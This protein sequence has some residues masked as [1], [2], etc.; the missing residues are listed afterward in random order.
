LPASSV[1]RGLGKDPR[2][3][4]ER[5]ASLNIS[6]VLQK[7]ASFLPRVIQANFRAKRH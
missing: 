5:C 7:F 6:V 2:C 1:S 3:G 4:S